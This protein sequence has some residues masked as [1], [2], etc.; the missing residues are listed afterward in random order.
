MFPGKILGIGLSCD[1]KKDD[2][3]DD[4]DDDGYDVDGDD[5][6]TVAIIVNGKAMQGYGITITRLKGHDNFSRPLAVEAGAV[7][8]FICKS[9]NS[10]AINTV[11]SLNIELIID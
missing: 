2:N 10:G 7:V 8:N 3:D 1:K 9:D 11:V 6:V 4:G 5:D